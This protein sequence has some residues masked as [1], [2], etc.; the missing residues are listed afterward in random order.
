M[1]FLCCCNQLLWTLGSFCSAVVLSHEIKFPA[2]CW[3]KNKTKKKWRLFFGWLIVPAHVNRKQS[4][5][6]P[7]TTF[8]K[9]VNQHISSL[10]CS[11]TEKSEC[12]VKGDDLCYLDESLPVLDGRTAND[13]YVTPWSRWPG[14]WKWWKVTLAV[15]GQA[16]RPFM[17][18]SINTS[19]PTTRTHTFRTNRPTNIDLL[20]LLRRSNNLTLD[21]H[22]PL[23]C[24]P[25]AHRGLFVLNR[26]NTRRKCV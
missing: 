1:S 16:R 4:V 17:E 2:A 26:N 21:L 22:R 24:Q 23:P 19:R 12:K 9:D 8:F 3:D 7:H 14:A 25:G 18:I 6:S 20:S 10:Y 11:R 15:Q 13:T 5:T